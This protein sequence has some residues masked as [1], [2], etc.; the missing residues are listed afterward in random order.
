MNKK[1]MIKAL[2][3]HFGVKATYLGVPSCAY[4]LLAEEETY[5]IERTGA[6]RNS[7]GDE[8]DVEMILNQNQT[9]PSSE[10][11]AP[12]EKEEA[13]I[14]GVQVEFPFDGHT[15][16]TLKN[17]VNMLSSKQKLIASAFEFKEL[18][19]DEGFAEDL[20]HKETGT[21]EQFKESF[22]EVGPE[23]CPGLTLDFEKET[24]RFNLI[25]EKLNQDKISAFKDLA[26]FI[27]KYA[28][29]LKNS[30]FKP[31]QEEN[32]KYAFRTW[33]IRL[34]MNGEEY[35]ASRKTL[36][37]ALEGSSAFRKPREENKAS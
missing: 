14:D 7:K 32:P 11:I 35:K 17:I 22:L 1:E 21:I 24:F 16:I 8:V 25:A 37:A 6:I 13:L 29:T 19:L 2:E 26:V 33:L 34:G 30:S 15:G 18:L 10:T 28:K 12:A 23:R 36:L 9:E 20:S 5:T 27:T 4:E 3:A 31:A